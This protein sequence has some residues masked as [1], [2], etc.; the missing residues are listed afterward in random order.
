MQTHSQIPPGLI[1][2]LKHRSKG[3][4]NIENCSKFFHFVATPEAIRYTS[5]SDI[6]P[7]SFTLR[8][9]YLA[10]MPRTPIPIVSFAEATRRI[11]LPGNAESAVG[12]DFVWAKTRP[13]RAVFPGGIVNKTASFDF[14]RL[15]RFLFFIL[16]AI[17]SPGG[18]LMAQNVNAIP[19]EYRFH[20][21]QQLNF[22]VTV[23]G[24]VDVEM[25]DGV[26]SNPVQ[27][28]M[29]IPQTTLEVGP[30]LA[31][32]AISIESAKV[33][34]GTDSAAL[35]E[36]GQKAMMT[37][38]KRG[39]IQFMSGASGWQGSEFAQMQFP[40]E[41][42]QIGASWV[43]EAVT[44]SEP[45]V[46]TK[47]RYTFN[48]FGKAAGRSC[49]AFDAELLLADSGQT[50]GSPSA[51]SK[52]RTYFDFELGQVVQTEADARF[53]FNLPIPDKPGLLAKS[54]TTI[55]TVMQ[56]VSAP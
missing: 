43:Q 51:I 30:D 33:L 46:K 22:K 3:V 28:D 34:N 56:L 4:K 23:R 2:I 55:R 31:T 12:S 39:R 32:I 16:A 7:I 48:G 20:P 50:M 25:P 45:P 9:K 42:L 14:M 37:V 54:T 18:C 49:A 27:I 24:Q 19:F 41:P 47:T 29:M 35:P 8:V 17:E 15:F 38:D 44:Q 26:R 52:G 11:P 36:E 1:G 6:S 10:S 40:E 21:G 5:Y 13:H 53:S